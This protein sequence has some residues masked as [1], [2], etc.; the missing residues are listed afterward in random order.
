MY[1]LRIAGPIVIGMSPVPARR[2]LLFNLIGAAIW[3]VAV[4]GV[5]FLFGHTLEWL[6]T[7]LSRYEWVAA[8]AI[9][10]MAGLVALLHRFWSARKQ[11]KS[12]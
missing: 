11:R 4:A 3:S 1:G 7:D 2:F 5:G 6:L 9:I 10:G 12:Q 8:L